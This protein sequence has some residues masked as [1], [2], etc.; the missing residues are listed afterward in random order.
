MLQYLDE[1]SESRKEAHTIRLVIKDYQESQDLRQEWIDRNLDKETLFEREIGA[2][3][4]M[5]EKQRHL[6]KWCLENQAKLKHEMET[7]SGLGRANLLHQGIHQYSDVKYQC[8]EGRYVKYRK[9]SR[10]VRMTRRSGI[11]KCYARK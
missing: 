10:P 9:L 2:F 11:I 7:Y 3:E 5:I 8:I 4:K 1:L 6:L